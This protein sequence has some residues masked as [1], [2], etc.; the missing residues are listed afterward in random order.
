M[1]LQEVKTFF[2]SFSRI[3]SEHKFL[4]SPH[5]LFQ[6]TFCH[7]LIRA[8]RLRFP[9]GARSSDLIGFNGLDIPPPDGPVCEFWDMFS[10]GLTARNLICKITELA[11]LFLFPP[12]LPSHS[13]S[14]LNVT[15]PPGFGECCPCLWLIKKKLVCINEEGSVCSLLA[16]VELLKCTRPKKLPIAKLL[17]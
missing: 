9:K 10:W 7:I 12:T 11:L 2:K 13:I 16:G 5:P 4:S 6:S 1:A 15:E 3:R 17:F 8:V 14:S